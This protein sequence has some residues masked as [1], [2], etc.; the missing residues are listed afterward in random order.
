MFIEFLLTSL[1]VAAIPGTGVVYT[2]S[3]SIGGGWRRGF[4]AAIG[5]TLGI[6][7]HMVAAMFGLSG[8]MQAGAVMFETVRWAGVAYLVFMGASMIRN[9]GALTLD[10]HKAPAGSV[11][12][13]VRRGMLLNLLNPKLTVFFFAFLPQF[14]D[15]S[16]D[17]L[18]T[19]L[20]GLGGIFMLVTLAVFAVYAYVSSTI[21]DR[22]LGAP[23]VRRWIERSLGTLLIG[24]AAK[25]AVTDR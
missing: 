22:I 21:R 12:L 16:P 25:L 10:D 20:V 7:P 17:L 8:I 19:K 6:I 2:V 24:F 13:V 11:G 18:N 15:P 23:V 9:D 14:L 5:C 4:V 3:T 1:V